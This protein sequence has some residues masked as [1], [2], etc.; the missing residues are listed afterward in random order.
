[1]HVVPLPY[2]MMKSCNIDAKSSCFQTEL[3]D[4]KHSHNSLVPLQVL[5]I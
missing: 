5:K 4:R 1:M 2:S 3:L